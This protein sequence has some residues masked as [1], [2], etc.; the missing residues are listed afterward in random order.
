MYWLPVVI[1]YHCSMRDGGE[2]FAFVEQPTAPAA[3]SKK[4]NPVSEFCR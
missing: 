1:G 2:L 3:G 4:P